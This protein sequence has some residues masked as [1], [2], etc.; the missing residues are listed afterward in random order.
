MWLNVYEED[1]TDLERREFERF[2]NIVG[3]DVKLEKGGPLVLQPGS[4]GVRLDYRPQVPVGPER[5][6]MVELPGIPDRYTLKQPIQFRCRNRSGNGRECGRV[7]VKTRQTHNIEARCPEC[8]SLQDETSVIFY[9]RRSGLPMVGRYAVP[10]GAAPQGE[11]SIRSSDY[12]IVPDL[13]VILELTLADKETGWAATLREDNRFVQAVF[14]GDGRV[15]VLVNG[16]PSRVEHRALAAIHP[17]RSNRVEFYVA[18]GVAR[19]FVD[20]VETPVLDVPVWNDRRPLPRNSPRSSGVGIT[21]FGG[22][23]SIR[24]LYIDRDVFYYSGWEQERGEKFPAMNSQGEV[25]IG[26]GSFLPIGDHCPSSFDARSWGPVPTSLLR[27]PALLVW[28]PP[29]RVGRIASP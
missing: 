28:W 13:R 16:E 18:A 1:F 2:W 20:S 10:P 26:E 25:V 5:S 3:D 11:T 9:H 4:G 22:E 7:F 24:R 15:E 19:I 6:A 8:G 21:A 29:D 14:S 23:V 12:H 27:G 17:G